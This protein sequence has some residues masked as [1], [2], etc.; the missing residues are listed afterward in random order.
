M[1]FH[2]ENIMK[3][4]NLLC[5]GKIK[6]KYLRDGIE[7]YAKRLSRFCSFSEIQLPDISGEDEVKRESDDILSKIKGY[8]ILCDIDGKQL[9]SEQISQ[10]MDKAY[11]TNSEITFIIG[12]SRGVDERVKSRA[13]LR[14]SFGK[15]TL[16]HQLMRLVLTEQIYRAFNISENTPYHK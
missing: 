1:H 13:D 11:L 8:V 14:L 9:S 5:V 2:L 4:V 10:T 7:E 6:E 16:P 15:A 3:K 12:G